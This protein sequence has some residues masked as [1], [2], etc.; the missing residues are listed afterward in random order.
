MV[1]G[2]GTCPLGGGVVSTV[3]FPPNIQPDS[4]ATI[5]TEKLYVAP[6]AMFRPITS[7]ISK[8]PLGRF[9]DEDKVSVPG[10]SY[11]SPS[12]PKFPDSVG[13]ANTAY[14]AV[15]AG[16]RATTIWKSVQVWP[17]AFTISK[18]TSL[19][20]PIPK[21]PAKSL[22]LRSVNVSCIRD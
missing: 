2:S 20:P 6:S 15:P 4:G 1:F 7:M 10:P 21:S 9:G 12:V 16:P 13:S 8:Y 22:K 19:L 18:E 17:V 11:V 5:S 3:G 14:P